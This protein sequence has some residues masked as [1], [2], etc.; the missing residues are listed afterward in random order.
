[1]V[2]K[3]MWNEIQLI[4][5]TWISPLLEFSIR[6]HNCHPPKSDLIISCNTTAHLWCSTCLCIEE[7]DREKTFFH[8]VCS[9]ER[10]ILF[11]F[12]FTRAHDAIGT[13]ENKHVMNAFTEH[14]DPDIKRTLTPHLFC[15]SNLN[16]LQDTG[17]ISKASHTA[18]KTYKYF[19]GLKALL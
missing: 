16:L 4:K 19:W 15:K 17:C 18:A 7:T 9:I 8:F 1:M 3:I 6:C 5:I 2:Y 10:R 14:W 13:P 12:P 11:L